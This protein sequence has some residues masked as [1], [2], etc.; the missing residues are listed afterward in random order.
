[1]KTEEAQVCGGDQP[2]RRL[3]QWCVIVEGEAQFWQYYW[4]KYCI[5]II[6]EE[7]NTIKYDDMK[8]IEES[9]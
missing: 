6:N 7:E 2:W 4:R 5:D 3:T 9:C 1:M 8:A